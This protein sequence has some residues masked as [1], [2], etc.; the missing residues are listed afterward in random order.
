MLCHARF[1]Q[2]VICDR[3]PQKKM[4]FNYRPLSLSHT[5]ACLD[6]TLYFF[7]FTSQESGE[8][9]DNFFIN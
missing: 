5:L 2:L 1:H 7:E 6:E 4:L 3:K 8:F 9:D